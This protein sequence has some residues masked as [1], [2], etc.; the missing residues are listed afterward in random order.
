M[1]LADPDGVAN[2]VV[3]FVSIFQQGFSARRERLPEMETWHKTA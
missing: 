2:P 1:G 3:L